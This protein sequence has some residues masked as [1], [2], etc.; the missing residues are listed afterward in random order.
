MI[1]TN[2]PKKMFIWSFDK[3][4]Y[5]VRH[6]EDIKSI[7]KYF[8]YLK[9][10]NKFKAFLNDACLKNSLILAQ[11]SLKKKSGVKNKS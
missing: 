3:A 8:C 11:C 6:E 9:H 1:W 2:Y 4:G 7:S 10:L 5:F